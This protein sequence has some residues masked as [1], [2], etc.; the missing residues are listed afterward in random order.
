MMLA[1]LR[2]LFGRLLLVIAVAG[3]IFATAPVDIVFAA[4]MGD[5][6]A[7]ITVGENDGGPP[8]KPGTGTTG[9]GD[10]DG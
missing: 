4:A 7:Y 2:S 3:V 8:T 6:Q 9:A 10:D 1:D 5:N